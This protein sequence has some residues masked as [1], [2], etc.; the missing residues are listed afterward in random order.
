MIASA[1]ATTIAGAHRAAEPAVT[2]LGSRR[3]GHHAAQLAA[4]R[5]LAGVD[6]LDAV[7]ERALDVADVLDQPHEAADL[8]RGGL[9]GA[10]HRAVEREVALDE[11]RA[12]RDRGPG[13]RQADLMAGVADRPV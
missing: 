8:D 6:A 4:A 2:A 1:P 13:R 11:A 9:I 3:G 10:P 7:A 5:Q 12:Q